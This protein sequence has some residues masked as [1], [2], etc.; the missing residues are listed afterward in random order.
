MAKG[1]DECYANIDLKYIK[2]AMLIILNKR[3]AGCVEFEMALEEDYEA[4]KVV[5]KHFPSLQEDRGLLALID[6]YHK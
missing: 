4:H 2:A 5:F 1:I 6:T 3:K